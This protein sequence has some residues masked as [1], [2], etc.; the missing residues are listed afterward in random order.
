[1]STRAHELLKIHK[2]YNH[3][4][5]FRPIIDATNTD[6]DEIARFLSSLL[7][8]LTKETDLQ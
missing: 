7:N 5:T 8:P 1:M 2:N 4:P 6:H 3:L